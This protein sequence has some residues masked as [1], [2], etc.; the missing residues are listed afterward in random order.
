MNCAKLLFDLLSGE[1]LT[2]FFFNKVIYLVHN[3]V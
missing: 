3:I 2:R 1:L